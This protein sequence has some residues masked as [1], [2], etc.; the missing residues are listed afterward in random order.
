MSAPV[1]LR[2]QY[3]HLYGSA[4]LPVLE[5][6]FRSELERHPSRREALFKIVSTDRDI[7][8]YS[9]LHDM[10]LYSEVQEGEDYSLSRPK[11]GASK[12]LSISKYGLGFSASE[13]MIDDGKFDL[14]ADMVR[15]L[16]KSGRESQEIAAMNMFNNGFSSETTADGVA[17]F[18]ASHTL[19]SGG[20]YRNVLSVDADLSETSLQQAMSDFETQFVGDSGIIENIKPRVLL[21]PSAQKRYAMELVGSQL[22]PDS[23]DN[24]LNSLKDD[25]LMVVSSPHLT[26]SDSW[27]ICAE[28]S[29]TGLRIVSRKGL[30]TKAA[31]PDSIGFLTDS[32]I[33]K[34]RYR[35]KI[36]VMHGKGI[37][38]SDGV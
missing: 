37:F 30:E 1:A 6:L 17:V 18:S 22:K 14:L 36:G 25:Q 35:E 4:A 23:A 27:F 19:P 2:S 3:S 11:Q 10:P 26:D 33:F 29:Q 15:L 21:V 16:A 32:I 8:Q 12:T 31:S 20:T 9:E 7:W 28:P 34:S 13:E 38:G 5:E 24:N